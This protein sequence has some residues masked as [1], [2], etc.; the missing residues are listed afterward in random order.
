MSE[1][2][3]IL[4]FRNEVSFLKHLAKRQASLF[5]MVSI[6][7]FYQYLILGILTWIHN[8]HTI[9]RGKTKIIRAKDVGKC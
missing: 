6:V 9:A 4:G 8:A 2:R 1:Q 3:G 5:I 7:G